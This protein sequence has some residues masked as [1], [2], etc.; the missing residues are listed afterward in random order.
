MRLA[1]LAVAFAAVVAS[2]TRLE[3][4]ENDE[5]SPGCQRREQEESRM[6][7]EHAVLL[8]SKDTK[9]L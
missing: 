4:D 3:H 1:E 7:L 5:C 8:R 9:K 6:G 2:S